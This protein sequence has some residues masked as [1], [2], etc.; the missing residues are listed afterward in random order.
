[1]ARKP[2]T[3]ATA[4]PKERPPTPAQVLET[5]LLQAYEAATEADKAK[6]NALV[7]RATGSKPDSAVDTITPGV[8]AVLF[9]DHNKQNREWTYTSTASYLEQIVKQEWE[10]TNQGIGFLVTGNVGDG[11]HRLAAI[12][13]SGVSVLALIAFGMQEKAIIALD[14]GR[15][16]QAADYLGIIHPDDDLSDMKRMQQMVTRA[17]G[18]LVK[19]PDEERRR[20]YVLRTNRDRATAVE[21]YKPLLQQAMAIA[22]EL[23]RGRRAPPFSE[24][25]AAAYA[26]MLLLSEGWTPEEVAVDL[27]Q[28]QSGEDR[29]GAESPCMS[30]G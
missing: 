20:P 7:A 16:R 27:D 14:T 22:K 2:K 24:G 11:Q 23:V 26:F 6:A 12:A 19:D 3:T 28:F 8:A 25:E 29:E 30:Q 18:Y 4:P 10:F 5:K 1:M 21:E 9:Y 13:L 17:F 15:R